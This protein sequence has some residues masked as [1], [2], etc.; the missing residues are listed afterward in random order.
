MKDFIIAC[1]GECEDAIGQDGR[2]TNAIWDDLR[3]LGRLRRIA[4]RMHDRKA[5]HAFLRAS[6][7]ADN[8]EY[9]TRQI[10]ENMVA[11]WGKRHV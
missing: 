2:M 11:H 4:R 8:G 6:W 10:A 1:I 9:Y 5:Y 3:G 7:L